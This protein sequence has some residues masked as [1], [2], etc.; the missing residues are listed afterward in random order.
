M[1]Y[2]GYQGGASIFSIVIITAIPTLVLIPIYYHIIQISR[3]HELRDN[4]TNEDNHVR[5]NK[6]LKVFLMVTVTFVICFSPTV[7]LRVVENIPDWTS[8]H[9][10]QFLAKWLMVANSAFNVFIYC[11]YNQAYRQTARKIYRHVLPCCKVSHVG[12]VNI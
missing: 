3:Q 9:W 2:Y 12:P 10:F 5:D 8:P 4:P 1:C 6:A 11:L 7:L